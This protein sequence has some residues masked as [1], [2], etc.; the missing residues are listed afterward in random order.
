MIIIGADSEK[1]RER[2][3]GYAWRDLFSGRF[4]QL[5]VLFNGLILTLTSYFALS[6]VISGIKE[7]E[8]RR[9]VSA[10]EKVIVHNMQT[11]GSSV[12]AVSA[13]IGVG[14]GRTE[15][16]LKKSIAQAM[17]DV[18]V[19]DHILLLEKNGNGQ[20]SARDL[21]HHQDISGS[22]HSRF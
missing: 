1:T 6:F 13:I 16:D 10:T 20:W 5:M 3:S 4:A 18:Q 12:H 19:Y 2:S 9:I 8:Y 22:I 21:Y 14:E 15:D 11:L 17:I 7:D